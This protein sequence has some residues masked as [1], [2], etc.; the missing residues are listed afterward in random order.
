M[1]FG[2]TGNL[3]QMEHVS[4]LVSA[5]SGDYLNIT[6]AVIRRQNG[7]DFHATQTLDSQKIH[8]TS[9]LQVIT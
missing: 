9:A 5:M 4:K 6:T 1:V 2:L 3:Q 7:E 8:M